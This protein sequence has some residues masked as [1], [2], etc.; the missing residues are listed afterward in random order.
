MSASDARI[1]PRFVPTLTDVVVEQPLS[2]AQSVE[3]ISAAEAVSVI[4]ETCNSAP[5][6]AAP[7]RVANV[8]QQKAVPVLSA[9]QA[10]AVALSL[11]ERVMVRLD[12]SLEERL[13]YA[14]ADMVQLHT[15][16]LYQAIRQD[17]EQLVSASVHE[18]IAQELADMRK[19]LVE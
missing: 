1:P 9:N 14:L 3:A 8:Q 13:R 17:V 5:Y 4:S 7:D 15:Q 2:V 11:Q 19:P 18:A 6:L 16:A 12:E 10:A